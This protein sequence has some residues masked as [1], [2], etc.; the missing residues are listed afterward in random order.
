MIAIND[1]DEIKK[2]D[3]LQREENYS[4]IKIKTEFEKETERIIREY[5]V[6][7]NDTLDLQLSICL[8]FL[9]YVMLVPIKS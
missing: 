2:E 1:F 4:N 5:N 3:E 6:T 8:G 7:E 9:I